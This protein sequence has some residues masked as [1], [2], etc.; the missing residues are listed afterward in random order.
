MSYLDTIATMPDLVSP[1]T[2][3]CQGCGA[4]LIVRRIIQIAGPDSIFCIPPGCLAGAGIVGWNFDNGMKVP[5]HITLLDNT[6]SFLSGMS[7]AYQS[8]DR[9]V[10][11]V[12][13]AGDGAS[14]DCGFQSLSGAAE[15]GEKMLYICYD[16]EGYMNTGFQRSSTSSKGSRTST[17]PVGKSIPGKPQHSKFMPFIMAL[18]NPVYAATASPSNMKDFVEKI[19]KG[20]AAAK[21]GFAYIHVFSPCPTGWGFNGKN[22]IEVARRAVKSNFFPLFECDRGVWKRNAAPKNPI[23]LK[24]FTSMASKF[25][26]LSDDDIHELELVAQSRI[27]FLNKMV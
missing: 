4:E 2:S 6:A 24:D 3:A 8:Q 5:V 21:E 10:N 15:R 14:A 22:S 11:M 23:P 1:G 12:A 17:T 13:I 26:H 16:N 20:L 27:D 25:K 19:E 18:H 9:D 7:N